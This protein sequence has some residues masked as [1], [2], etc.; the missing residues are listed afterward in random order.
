VERGWLV[1]TAARGRAVA[2]ELAPVRLTHK[3]QGLDEHVVGKEVDAA[4]ARW[5][6]LSRDDDGAVTYAV[7]EM[8]NNAIDHSGGKK[9]T[10][11]VSAHIDKLEIRIVDDGIGVFKRLAE[12][13]G[14][15]APKDALVQL[16][17]G[18]LTTMPERHSGEGIF[19]TSKIAR[20]FRLEAGDLAWIVDNEVNDRTV[21]KLDKR[22][23]G[24]TVVLTFV[25]GKIEKLE[26]VFR[27]YTGEDN[28]FTK[29]RTTVKLAE[30]SAQL[31]SR[32]EAKR[33]VAG[34]EKFAHVTLDFH[35]VERVG[36]GFVDEV[37]RVFADAHPAVELAPTRM[38]ES[39]AFM[40]GRVRPVDETKL[41]PALPEKAKAFLEMEPT[42]FQR[43]WELAREAPPLQE[44]RAV[45][46]Y[47]AALFGLLRLDAS[48]GEARQILKDFFGDTPRT[49]QVIDIAVAH[50]LNALHLDGASGGR[51][52]GLMLRMM[53]VAV[54]SKIAEQ[55][56]L[57]RY[58][59]DDEGIQRFKGLKSEQRQQL[60]GVPAAISLGEELLAL[61]RDTP[62]WATS[63]L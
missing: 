55:G 10:I 25:P 50:Y 56:R 35:G 40:I 28:A 19:F 15:T 57:W 20:R 21:E 9:V 16:E 27:R 58:F 62:A 33:V 4:I 54:L 5:F 43:S 42:R 49:R 52:G 24:T 47:G 31:L 23:K 12:Q 17:K 36:Q 34:L 13:A 46:V 18:K 8:V 61:L 51:F 7:T 37:F 60:I 3:L 53:L 22:V 39:V 30:V 6:H 63:A 32:S 11:D 45:L 48:T 14:L 44:E 38:N 41:P 26:D 59:V 29:T 1:R 2:Y